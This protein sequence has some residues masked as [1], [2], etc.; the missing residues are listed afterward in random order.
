MRCWVQAPDL[1]QKTRMRSDSEQY[2]DV[3]VQQQVGRNATV[4]QSQHV[5]LPMQVVGVTGC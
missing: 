3:P 5:S 1:H 2:F 4:C